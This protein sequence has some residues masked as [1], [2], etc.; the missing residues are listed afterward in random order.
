MYYEQIHLKKFRRMY[1]S[2]IREFKLKL[3]DAVTL[4]LGTNGSGK[5]CLLNELSPLPGNK[6]AFEKD[7]YKEVI[8]E[9]HNQRYKLITTFSNGVK[10]NFIKLNPDGSEEELN[11]GG[12][13]A[14]QKTLAEE[15]FGYTETIH[16]L[17][18]N[19]LK[20]TDMG[21]LKRRE[22]FT[23][24]S[25][26]NYDYVIGLYIKLKEK[27]RDLQGFLKEQKAKLLQ[28]E[29][30]KDDPEHVAK[31][32]KDTDNI[33]ELIRQLR[34]MVN[35]NQMVDTTEYQEQ[36][37]TTK[38][39]IKRRLVDY[40]G[41]SQRLQKLQTTLNLTED[42]FNIN[43]L[44]SEKE[45]L[46]RKKSEM[47]TL[48]QRNNDEMVK[49]EKDLSLLK[50]SQVGSLS[51]VD[52]T[53]KTIYQ[54]IEVLEG[55]KATDIEIINPSETLYYLRNIKET[56][57]SML[58]GIP[59]NDGRYTKDAYTKLKNRLFEIDETLR[60][61]NID[62]EKAIGLSKAL[63]DKMVTCPHCR[64]SFIPGSGDAEKHCLKHATESIDKKIDEALREKK[65]LQ[66]QY[67]EQ[68]TYLEALRQ[69]TGLMLGNTPLK[70][71]HE[72][73]I[74]NGIVTTNPNQAITL[75]SHYESDLTNAKSI[76]ENRLELKR[77]EEVKEGL[78]QSGM[79]S[80]Q[81][82][83]FTLD[84]L[85]KEQSE[86]RMRQSAYESQLKV[87]SQS[88]RLME[89]LK[90]IRMAIRDDLSAL[91]SHSKDL[92]KVVLDNGINEQIEALR[93]TQTHLLNELTN[94]KHRNSTIKEIQDSIKETE[95][96]EK[97]YA[98]L[99]EELSPNKGLIA[100]GLFSF[101]RY[102]LKDM[103]AVISKI[104]TYPL[105]IAI[106]DEMDDKGLTYRFPMLTGVGEEEIPDVNV[107]SA[108]IREI[109]NL[110]FKIVSMKYLRIS[111]YPLVLDEFG[112]TFDSSHRIQAGKVI[113]SLI[114]TRE[115]QQ[116]F[117]VSHYADA[118]GS[119]VN[120]N[121]V[122]IDDSNIVLPMDSY[123]QHVEITYA[124][125]KGKTNLNQPNEGN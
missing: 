78:A 93:L 42:N 89:I 33:Q 31:L 121:I 79:K 108:G 98:L 67:E 49:L 14:V 116:L 64:E 32:L 95:L 117:M 16:G 45:T 36:Y 87:I 72:Y 12:T 37:V 120:C 86:L 28:L 125:I 88:I 119:M 73:L 21:P 105:E 113:N 124:G 3:P 68:E 80:V 52:N 1:L 47:D 104:W 50:D 7:G 58:S 57:V 74:A 70:P 65:A 25:N 10:C 69:Y 2:G 81:E 48:Y 26:V 23:T 46:I 83:A 123:N 60:K 92:T 109:V 11:T 9:H 97:A 94:A 54:A 106:A 19:K 13:Q 77:L 20:F 55:N 41:N 82:L 51:E 107:G 96:K 103:N 56:I 63:D 5:S 76:E 18:N 29:V 90:D 8:I 100:E 30:I 122:V 4:I 61:L 99:V 39:H 114:S 53:V 22:W 71:F 102:F 27:H 40:I 84:K 66:G 6:D 62:K 115:H 75:L 35:H 38:N 24:L 85:G 15:I 44:I 111:D 91:E 34:N 101:I 17:I 43:N 110:A 59:F 112:A 118:Y